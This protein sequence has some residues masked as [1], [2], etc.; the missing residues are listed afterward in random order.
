M[1]EV[2]VNKISPRSGTN[3]QLGDS[4]DTITVPSGAT[5]DASNATT[6][7]PANVVTTTGSQTLTNKTINSANNTITI[8]EA[9]I[10]DLG[11]YITASSTDTLTNKFPDESIRIRST[12]A[13][14][15]TNLKNALV[16]LPPKLRVLLVSS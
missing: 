8:T 15:V 13:P 14:P 2:K 7:L 10:S 4:G 5:L 3:V 9:N 1:S 6:T 12:E 11:S 16:E